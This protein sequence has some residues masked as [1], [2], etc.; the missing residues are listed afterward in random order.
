MLSTVEFVEIFLVIYNK[1]TSMWVSRVCIQFS[2]V[3]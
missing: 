2:L 3:K 1:V